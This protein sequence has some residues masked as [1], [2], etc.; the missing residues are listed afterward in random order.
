LWVQ[1]NPVRSKELN[2][3]RA[4]GK[5]ENVCLTPPQMVSVNKSH[6]VLPT[7]ALNKKIVTKS[8]FAIAKTV[9]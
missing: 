7:E 1:V 4:S 3:I 9:K 2:N 5:D 8:C 6:D